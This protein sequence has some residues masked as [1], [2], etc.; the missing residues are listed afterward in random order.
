[1]G[2]DEEWRSLTQPQAG[3][4]RAEPI[5]VLPLLLK[6]GVTYSSFQSTN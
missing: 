6:K 4:V 3:E 5:L 2:F 1:M